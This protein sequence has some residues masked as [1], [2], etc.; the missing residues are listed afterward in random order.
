[1]PD[2]FGGVQSAH[3]FHAEDPPLCARTM[4]DLEA[5]L[6]GSEQAFNH[7]AQQWK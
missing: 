2:L 5:F 3:L 6:Y 7:F 4:L 1:L